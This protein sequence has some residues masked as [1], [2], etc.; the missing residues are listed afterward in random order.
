MFGNMRKKKIRNRLVA[1]VIGVFV[2]AFGIWLNYNDRAE[3]APVE[4][5]VQKVKIDE[6]D[7]SDRENKNAIGEKSTEE[8][9]TQ[10]AQKTYLIEEVDGVVK[11]FICDEKEKKEL[12]LITSIPF[13]LLSENDQKLFREGVYLDTEEDLGKFLENFDS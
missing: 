4:K 13:E 10:H 8:T 2:L 11:V 1:T 6:A 9:D 5:T 3:D 12:Y 7:R